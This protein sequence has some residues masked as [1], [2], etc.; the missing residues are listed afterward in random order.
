MSP[1]SSTRPAV[2]ERSSTFEHT[3]V[4]PTPQKASATQQ[5]RERLTWEKCQ[6][7]VVFVLFVVLRAMDRV[8][9]KRVIDRMKNYEI[10]YINIFWPIGV[11]LMTYALCGAWVA[12]HR[13]RLKDLEYGLSFFSP[14]ATI[15]TAHGAYPQ[16]RLALFSFWDQLNAIIT[17]LPAPFIDLTSQS[18][19]SNFGAQGTTEALFGAAL[20]PPKHAAPPRSSWVCTEPQRRARGGTALVPLTRARARARRCRRSHHL[21]GRHFVPVPRHTLCS[22]ALS[23]LRPHPHLCPRVR[24]RA[25]ADRQPT[26]RPVRAP[27]RRAPLPRALNA[28]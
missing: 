12:Y 4:E 14:R 20:R 23:R 5:V 18:I 25:A 27:P 19:M 7:S 22:R 28:P 17:S 15:A 2:R 8:F 11:Q 10:M 16:W 26:S 13:Y 3:R 9:N 24:H 6:L 21:H 1:D